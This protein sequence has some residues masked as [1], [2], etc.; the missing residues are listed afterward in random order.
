MLGKVLAVRAVRGDVDD[1][2]WCAGGDEGFDLVGEAKLEADAEMALL[3][4]Q[5]GKQP[6]GRIAAIEHEQ[7]VRLQ[8]VELL[9]QHAALVFGIG[10][11]I[12]AQNQA[13]AGFA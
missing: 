1:G 4:E 8:V 5:E 7:V 12:G 9:G 2:T 13:G 11:Q 10:G 3:G 6:V